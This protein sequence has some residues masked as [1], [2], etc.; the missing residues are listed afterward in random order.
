[1]SASET[2]SLNITTGFLQ[3]DKGRLVLAILIS[4]VVTILIGLASIDSS[5]ETSDALGNVT[6]AYNLAKYGTFSDST[7]DHAAIPPDFRR[8]PLYPIWI[9]GLL[10]VFA[11][12]DDVTL[13]CF[14]E[15]AACGDLRL[16]IKWG[17]IALFIALTTTFVIAAYIITRKWQLVYLGLLLLIPVDYLNYG[18]ALS[19]VPAAL[20]LLLH[21]ILMYMAVRT[22]PDRRKF[23][24]YA[25]SSS[26]ALGLLALTKAIFFYWIA[27][28]AVGLTVYFII[29]GRK[30]RYFISLAL[31]L[32]LPAALLTGAWI[33]RNYLIS[34]QFKLA[35]RDGQVLAVRAEFTSITPR[36]YLA[37][38]AY[39][40][41]PSLYEWAPA[42]HP[43]TLLPFTE[44]DYFH[45][46]RDNPESFWFR[47][48]TPEGLVRTQVLELY[49]PDAHDENK[50][51]SVAFSIIRENWHKHALLTLT[52]AYRGAFVRIYP[53]N[54]EID[55]LGPT[56]SRLIR[57]IPALPIAIMSAFYFPA[58]LWVVGR[59]AVNKHYHLMIFFLPVMYSFGIHAV[60]THYIPRYSTPLVPFFII[61]F[62]IAAGQVTDT[63]RERF[64]R[65][66]LRGDNPA[67]APEQ[68]L[69]ET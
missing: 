39:Y 53:H 4:T 51:S 32:I 64:A 33:G 13:E 28:L 36:E 44:E 7:E 55:A 45:L 2:A 60:A 56:V 11:D 24:V 35:G 41:L 5:P 27:V 17:N 8:E 49:G 68:V 16:L 43:R 58:F 14:R 66:K 54:I 67:I 12:L 20:L 52:F 6:Y 15:E 1:M 29:R 34:N 26:I 25:A 63:V 23:L 48:R 46:D 9:S 40:T 10:R 61:T 3:T 18:R 59:A 37:A 19:E 30:Q 47:G 57:F 42:L 65:H 21:A 31:S 69:K 22:F 38:F 62:V 50:L